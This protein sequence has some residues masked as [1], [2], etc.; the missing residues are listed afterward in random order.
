VE[1]RSHKTV[2]VFASSFIGNAAGLGIGHL[3]AKQCLRYREPSYDGIVS[4]CAALP[5]IAAVLAAMVLPA[6]GSSAASGFAGRTD[7]SEGRLAPAT[8]GAAM[9]LVPGYALVMT[10]KR[11]HSDGLSNVGYALLLLGPP[12]LT[13]AADY[14]FRQLR[15]KPESPR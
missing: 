6:L 2:L 13:T 7:L 1:P 11:N 14:L 8:V 4:D 15:G 12:V 5:T 10:G 3:A 9:T